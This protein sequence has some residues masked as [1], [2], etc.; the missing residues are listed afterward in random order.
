[1]GAPERRHTQLRD[2]SVAP[3]VVAS[4]VDITYRVFGTGTGPREDSDESPERRALTRLV[5]GGRGGRG[6]RGERGGRRGRGGVGVREVHA[7]RDVSFVAYPGESIGI[8]GRNGSGKS[9]LL[10]SIAGLV[11]PTRGSIWL[12][13]RASLLGVGAVLMKDLTGRQNV[14]IGGLAMGLT[15]R[16]VRAR[17][18]DIIDFAGIGSF[19]DLPMGT[20]SSGMAARLRFAIST[21]VVP[22]ILVVDEALATGDEEF[23]DRAAERIEEIRKEAGTVFLVS[24]SRGAIKQMCDRLLWMDEGRLLADGLVEPVFGLYTRKYG[25]GRHIWR[26]RYEEM[27][28][29]MDEQGLE[30]ARGLLRRYEPEG[31]W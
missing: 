20:Y 4:H 17:M 11:P 1:M 18:D 31:G 25:K 2:P 8:I 29:V 26:E 30:A 10:R 28:R 14:E 3:S 22:D 15:P 13:G 23:R 9:T 5:G 16:E 12:G 24:H 19:I 27:Q 6:G 7:V 21:A